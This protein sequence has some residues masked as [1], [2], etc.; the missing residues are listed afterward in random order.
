MQQVVIGDSSTEL[1][2][3]VETSA[4]AALSLTDCEVRL[5]L[6]G[7]K[8]V[9][10][11]ESASVV[12]ATSCTFT[13]GSA[14]VTRASGSFT[15]DGV[16]VGMLVIADGIIDGS[17]VTAVTTLS[18]TMDTA[19]AR[20]GTGVVRFWFGILTTIVDAAAGTVKIPAIAT[21]LDPGAVNPEVYRG[22]VRIENN[23]SGDVAWT[24]P[25]DD[26]VIFEAIRP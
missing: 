9:D 7:A 26:L 13:A 4:G 10:R 25:E 15:G 24:D 22:S 23:G 14:T 6:R 12:S 17:Q 11:P 21:M 2:I 1:D 3:T 5:F 8:S 20:S 19:A 18:V 16:E